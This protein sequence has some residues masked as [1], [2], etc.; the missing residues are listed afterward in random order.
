MASITAGAR[1]SRKSYRRD[2]RRV[3]GR[4]ALQVVPNI[5]DR[6]VVRRIHGSLRVVLPT[7]RRG[8][9][10]FAG[11]ENRLTQRESSRRIIAQPAGESLTGELARGAV[12]VADPNVASRVDGGA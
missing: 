4:A 2:S 3:S 10:R 8:L 1:A 6:A 5:P 9:R 7:H 11:Y 12:R